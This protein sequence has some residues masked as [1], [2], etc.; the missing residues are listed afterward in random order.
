[1]NVGPEILEVG[2]VEAEGEGVLLGH[3]EVGLQRALHEDERDLEDRPP[4]VVELPVAGVV[5]LDLPL[6]LLQLGRVARLAV[7]DVGIEAGR[8]QPDE[9]ERHGRVRLEGADH[10]LERVAVRLVV[11]AVRVAEADEGVDERGLLAAHHAGE[12]EIR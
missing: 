4:E 12:H 3:E 10:I 5:G 2:R 8:E 1:M 11:G 6:D 9:R 7:C